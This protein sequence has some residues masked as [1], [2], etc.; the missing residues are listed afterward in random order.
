MGTRHRA[1]WISV[2]SLA[3]RCSPLGAWIVAAA[4]ASQDTC[5][6]AR[7]WWV[8]YSF[9]KIVHSHAFRFVPYRYDARAFQALAKTSCARS[10]DSGR[11]RLTLKENARRNGRSPMSS[12]S[13][14]ASRSASELA[15]NASSVSKASIFPLDSAAAVPDERLHASG[16][17]RMSTKQTKSFRVCS[18][19]RAFE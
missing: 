1:R 7:R 9:L 19:K 10:S 18:A 14:S 6:H 17:L 13:N 16:S 4:S 3:Q 11:C 8:P 12:A 5:R 2:S 15:D